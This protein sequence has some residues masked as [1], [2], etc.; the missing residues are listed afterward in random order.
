MSAGLNYQ[1][2]E[3]LTNELADET[4]FSAVNCQGYTYVSLYITGTGTTSSGV[5]TI[6]T[7]DYNPSTQGQANPYAGTWSAITTVNAVDVT[8][9]AQKLVALTP[10][11]YSYIRA[12]IT[13]VIGGT[14]TISVVLIAVSQ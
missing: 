9:G 10:A 8:G 14:G 11:A 3:L 12:R 13:T 2:V 6:E 1:R 7:A 5:I 4:V